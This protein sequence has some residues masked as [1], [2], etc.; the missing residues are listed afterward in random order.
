MSIVMTILPTILVMSAVVIAAAPWGTS[1]SVSFVLPL[2]PYMMAHLFLAR[3]KGFVPSPVMFLAG[4]AMDTVSD[5]PLGFWAWIYL[6]GVLVAR[7]LPDGLVHSQF[8]RFTGLLLIVFALTAAQVGLASLYQL[9][10]IEWHEVFAGTL[11][12]GCITALIDLAWSVVQPKRS[13]N[14]TARGIG[15]GPGHV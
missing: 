14:V 10:W 9:R 13:I 15:G 4:L 11:V 7:Q 5:S 6:F 12:A 8:G 2:M 3:G 1:S